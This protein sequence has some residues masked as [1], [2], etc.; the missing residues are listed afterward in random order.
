KY[1]L[2]D[3]VGMIETRLSAGDPHFDRSG[4]GEESR[5][6]QLLCAPLKLVESAGVKL[7]QSQ[8]HS[9]GGAEPQIGQVDLPRIAVERD[10]ARLFTP[11]HSECF[12]LTVRYRF[13]P[14]RCNREKLDSSGR[15]S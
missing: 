2:G 7:S 1:S 10:A 14:R 4:R 6:V 15:V 9:T 3:G 5:P 13:E 8:E 12:Q 11:F